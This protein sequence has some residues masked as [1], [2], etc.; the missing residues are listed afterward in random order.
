ML[1]R[2]KL[3]VSMNLSPSNTCLHV[4]ALRP[5]KPA[6]TSRSKYQLS[7]ACTSPSS[8]RSGKRGEKKKDGTD[9]KMQPGKNIKSGE[10]SARNS[11]RDGRRRLLAAAQTLQHSKLY[12]KH[13][14]SR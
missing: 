5:R 10:E 13:S 7:E 8:Q 9:G 4:K 2:I 3:K 12:S 14:R 1:S 6:T 11:N